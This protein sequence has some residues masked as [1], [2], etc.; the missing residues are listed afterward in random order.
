MKAYVFEESKLREACQL[1]GCTEK[2]NIPANGT[3]DGY[4]NL[5]ILPT[6][7]TSKGSLTVN[8]TFTHAVAFWEVPRLPRIA[9]VE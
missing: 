1:T 5:T 8:N 2:I 4:L 3:N 9:V 6:S 7:P